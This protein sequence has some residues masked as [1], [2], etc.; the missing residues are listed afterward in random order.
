MMDRGVEGRG[1]GEASASAVHEA[2]P[3]FLRPSV[4]P[5]P[6]SCSAFLFGVKV[7]RVRNPGPRRPF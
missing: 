6:L 3:R 5:L 7:R 2:C 1:V 4:L